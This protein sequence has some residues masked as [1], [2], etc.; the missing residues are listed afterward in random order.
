M[1]LFFLSPGKRYLIPLAIQLFQEKGD[2]N[3]V[4]SIFL[5]F[6]FFN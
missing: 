3:P 6:T 4:S 5:Y 1:A 2:N